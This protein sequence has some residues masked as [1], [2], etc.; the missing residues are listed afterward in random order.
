MIIHFKAA[1]KKLF[2]IPKTDEVL[3][4]EL[5]FHLQPTQAITLL[6]KAKIP[7]TKMS[8]QPVKM[9][10]D[11][12]ESFDSQEGGTS[13]GYEILI[14]DAMMNDPTLFSRSDLVE[15]SWEITEPILDYWEKNP[16][17]DFPNYESGS[18]GPDAS[19]KLIE[20][21]GHKWRD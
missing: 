8:L 6:L 19:Y 20:R 5:R 10:F 9:H 18:W 11:Y 7:G 21:D 13:T 2:Q 12:A 4:N 15:K 3:T 17:T 16:P 14:Y 1:P